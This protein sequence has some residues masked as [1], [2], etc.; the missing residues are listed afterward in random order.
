MAVYDRLHGLKVVMHPVV[1]SCFKK[2]C[3]SLSW[4]KEKLITIKGNM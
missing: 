1:L 4:E 2:K 3:E